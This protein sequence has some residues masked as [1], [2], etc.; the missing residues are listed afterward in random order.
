[1]LAL[2]VLTVQGRQTGEPTCPWD[3][4]KLSTLGGFLS[5]VRPG[6]EQIL[7]SPDTPENTRPEAV[8]TPRGSG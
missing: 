5:T 6:T 3:S 4:G 8:G 2:E 1:M 7:Q